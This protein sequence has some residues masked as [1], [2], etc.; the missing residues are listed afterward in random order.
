M[1]GQRILIPLILVRFQVPLPITMMQTRKDPI[2]GKVYHVY[3]D[4]PPDRD[5]L[6]DDEDDE[7]ESDEDFDLDDSVY[8]AYE[9]ELDRYYS[10]L[11]R[12]RW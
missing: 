9:R 10:W 1:V 5:D 2:T 11:Y 3:D 8:R 4:E 12:D 7:E 6:E